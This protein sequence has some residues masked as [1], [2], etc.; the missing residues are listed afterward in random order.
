MDGGLRVSGEKWGN[1]GRRLCDV[2]RTRNTRAVSVMLARVGDCALFLWLKRLIICSV[3]PLIA[4]AKIPQRK[5]KNK[6]LQS[7]HPCALTIRYSVRSH[8][9]N[10]DLG[11]I[12]A[13]CLLPSVCT[14]RKT[15]EQLHFLLRTTWWYNEIHLY[16]HH[17]SQKVMIISYGRFWFRCSWKTTI[18]IMG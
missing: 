18:L 17:F 2:A 13:F 12:V 3:S 9:N 7:S 10:Q 15:L 14:C 5:S 8:N 11:S 1:A 4:A 6:H 16:H